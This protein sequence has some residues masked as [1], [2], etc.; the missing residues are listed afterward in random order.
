MLPI[1]IH[2]VLNMLNNALVRRKV[3][4]ANDFKEILSKVDVMNS[5]VGKA[6]EV[7]KQSAGSRIKVAVV[8]VVA[9]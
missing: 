9:C 3:Q 6:C 2:S 5:A 7:S 4:G 8:Y 1:K